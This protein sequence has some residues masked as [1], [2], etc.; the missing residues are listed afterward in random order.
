MKRLSERRRLTAAEFETCTGEFERSGRSRAATTPLRTGRGVVALPRRGRGEHAPGQLAGFLP[1]DMPVHTRPHTETVALQVHSRGLT[2]DCRPPFAST[3]DG[4]HLLTDHT[5]PWILTGRVTNSDG[6]A[7]SGVLVGG[8]LMLTAHTLRPSR[9]IARGSWWMTFSPHFDSGADPNAPFGSSDVSDLAHYNAERDTVYGAGHDFML[10]RLFEPMGHQ[11]G[12]LGATSFADNWRGLQVWHS[13][14]YPADMGGGTRP[15]VRINQSVEHDHEDDNGRYIET[16]AGLDHGN[17]AGLF[18]SWF[19]DG[20]VRL[21]GVVS[22][23]ESVDGDLAHAL[24][25]GDDMVS[26]INWGRS[27]WPA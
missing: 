12:F 19:D 10:C 1:K 4:R 7:G 17:A 18:F 3:G 13:I 8:R 27:T 20:H 5:W 24:A 26:L 23:A 15:A 21:C 22:D 9:S 14:G 16:E 2:G 6:M 25:S 11:L